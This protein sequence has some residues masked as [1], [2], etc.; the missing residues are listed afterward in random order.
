MSDNAF[1]YRRPFKKATLIPNWEK[2][3]KITLIE[4]ENLLFNIL[5]E[6][7]DKHI[8]AID[9]ETTSLDIAYAQIVGVSFSFNDKEGYYIPLLHA[10]SK[11]LDISKVSKILNNFLKRNQVVLMYNL[12]FDIPILEKLNIDF[13]DKKVFDVQNLTYLKDTNIHL[14]SLKECTEFFLGMKTPTFEETLG[15]K[16]NFSELTSKE[17]YFYAGCDAI[18]TFGLYNR[19]LPDISKECPNILKLDNQAAKVLCFLSRSNFYIK[20]EVVPDIIT[21]YH[22]EASNYE[23]AF[24]QA[25]GYPINI[26]SNKQLVEALTKLGINTG[27]LTKGGKSGKKTMSVGAEALEAVQSKYPMLKNV[28]Q[29]NSLASIES[30]LKKYLDMPNIIH[31]KYQT[32]NTPHGR[33]SSGG[34]KDLKDL[35]K[36]VAPYYAKVNAQNFPTCGEINYKAVP[37]KSEWNIEGYNF[38]TVYDDYRGA[39][40]ELSDYKSNVRRMIH[41][42]SP[43]WYFLNADYKG[44][45]LKLAANFSHE[46]NL[47]VP[48]KQGLDLHRYTAE[49]MYGVENYT[50]ELRG[51]GKIMN[52]LALYLGGADAVMSNSGYKSSKEEAE[53]LLETYWKTMSTLRE[54]IRIEINKAKANPVVKTFYGRPRRLHF[55]LYHEFY[56]QRAFGERSVPSQIVAG[57]LGDIIRMKLVDCYN[58]LFNNPEFK[59][60]VKFVMTVHDSI[61]FLIRR[62]RIQEVMPIINNIMVHTE[63]QWELPLT[64]EY[65]LGFSH[66]FAVPF[67]LNEKTKKWELQIA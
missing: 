44:A 25:L 20:K 17:A 22:N 12:G 51:K 61:E 29:Y 28:V 26:R 63:P 49:Q 43:D 67:D 21:Y 36:D 41:S 5:K 10:N 4:D 16:K 47:I 60:D 40:L 18:T 64:M 38:E 35:P 39:V 11:N 27:K 3:V 30:G 55:Y 2:D 48:F 58:Q 66:G 45:E 31:C 8:M 57:T 37:A 6:N 62:E 59:D 1:L 46:P 32:C 33:L 53:R 24:F 7:L 15:D 50:K 52:F 23:R 42:P 54:W 65:E 34:E 14:P 13:R 19:L 9:T 56:G